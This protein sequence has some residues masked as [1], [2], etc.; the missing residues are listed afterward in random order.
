MFLTERLCMHNARVFVQNN[1]FEKRGTQ[2]T[3]SQFT[4]DALKAVSGGIRK[5]F[6][7]IPV[8]ARA[9]AAFA[10]RKRESSLAGALQ[11]LISFFRYPCE[12]YQEKAL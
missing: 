6:P 4:C 11:T 3:N 10:L 5:Y 12:F 2:P 1:R 7:E 8:D 9:R